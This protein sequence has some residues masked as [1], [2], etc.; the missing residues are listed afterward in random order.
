VLQLV[1]GAPQLLALRLEEALGLAQCFGLLAETLVGLLE[2]ALL[3]LQLPSQ[4]LRLRE[5]SGA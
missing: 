5:Q 3:V 4:G 1:V 2:L